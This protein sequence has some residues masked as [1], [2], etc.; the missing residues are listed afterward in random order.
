MNTDK[1]KWQ[2]PSMDFMGCY[3]VGRCKVCE[4]RDKEQE[5]PDWESGVE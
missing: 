1:C 4:Y 5:C 2:V 3:K